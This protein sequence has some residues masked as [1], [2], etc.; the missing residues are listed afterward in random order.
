LTSARARGYGDT[1][2]LPGASYREKFGLL[3]AP[4]ARAFVATWPSSPY[5]LPARAV[6]RRPRCRARV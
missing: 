5:V 3:S 6:G 2:S 1:L 4:A